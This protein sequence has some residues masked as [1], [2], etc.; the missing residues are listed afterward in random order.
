[1][2]VLAAIAAFERDRVVER[3]KAGLER[4]KAQG[5]RL[6]RPTREL[7]PAVVQLARAGSLVSVREA[8]R[9][10][11]VSRSTAQRWLASQKSPTSA[12]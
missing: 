5:K 9:R 3:V 12:T 2:A 6:G 10:L 11:G 7:P 1:M 4:A 8:A